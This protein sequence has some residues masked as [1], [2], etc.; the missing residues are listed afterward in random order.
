MLNSCKPVSKKNEPQVETINID[1]QNLVDEL[2]VDSIYTLTGYVS[3]ET[4]DRGLVASV[5][6]LLATEG[7][8][9]IFD[10]TQQAVFVFDKET[11][12]FLNKIARQ[13]RGPREYISIHDVI[14]NKDRSLIEILDLN[15]AKLM[16][17]DFEGNY[18]ETKYINERNDMGTGIANI[19][20]Q[21]Y[22]FRGL[23]YT[24]SLRKGGIGVF[25]FEDD[26]L[27]S[28]SAL[29]DIP[30][31]FRDFNFRFNPVYDIGEDSLYFNPFM[32]DTLF[33]VNKSNE[34][35]ADLVFKTDEASRKK[36]KSL[37]NKQFKDA[38]EFIEYITSETDFIWNL[39]RLHYLR[40]YLFF[41]ANYKGSVQSFIYSF[42]SRRVKNYGAIKS[43]NS[44]LFSTVI[45]KSYDDNSLLS[46]L[47]ITHMKEYFPN[48]V[49]D[50]I[51]VNDNP[52][53][54][55]YKIKDF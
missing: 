26:S 32:N 50:S 27:K 2:S 17:F 3:L 4:D 8:F 21:Y 1:T 37:E 33:V 39:D 47:D 41:T 9:I 31:S 45:A 13:G 34:I 40:D 15:G 42:K 22:F 18:A 30:D 25:Q 49:P 35:R 10:K 11:G 24:P 5:D 7:L 12:K 19:G 51:K 53:I 46:V 28:R 44:A 38:N 14:I 6:K 43:S 52:I 54:A 29:F 48:V 55:T 36:K 16:C 23:I 20:D